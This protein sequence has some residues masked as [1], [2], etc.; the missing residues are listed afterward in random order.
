MAANRE[1]GRG[2][3][4]SWKVR[5]DRRRRGAIDSQ[6]SDAAE[7]DIGEN[8]GIGCRADGHFGRFVAGRFDGGRVS[9]GHQKLAIAAEPGDAGRSERGN[10]LV[11]LIENRDVVR[12]PDCWRQKRRRSDR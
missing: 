12:R 1:G 4:E 8:P 10:L 5:A 9:G 6:A 2:L 7:N 3:V 11:R